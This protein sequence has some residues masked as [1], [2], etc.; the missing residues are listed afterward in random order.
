MDM[1]IE[2]IE[3]DGFGPLGAAVERATTQFLTT[4]R[5]I[6]KAM[7]GVEDAL[8]PV[9]RARLDD[10][11]GYAP[12]GQRPAHIHDWDEVQRIVNDAVESLNKMLDGIRDN[13]LC[14]HYVNV[15]YDGSEDDI[16]E[17]EAFNEDLARGVIS[18]DAAVKMIGGEQ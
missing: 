18:V 17:Q 10:P 5:P 7:H 14:D 13:A 8:A 12:Y 2:A 3:N 16:A 11:K 4:A 1:I 15:D 6:I 9:N